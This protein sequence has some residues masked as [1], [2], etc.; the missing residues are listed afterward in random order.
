MSIALIRPN[1]PSAN[2]S[3]VTTG[4]RPCRPAAARLRSAGRL[5]S[6]NT[7]PGNRQARAQPRPDLQRIRTPA[8]S[9][10]TSGQVL[11]RSGPT[12]RASAHSRS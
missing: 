1:E 9:D 10:C 12:S 4:A 5:I 2:G 3:A 8:A 11:N 6:A 7:V